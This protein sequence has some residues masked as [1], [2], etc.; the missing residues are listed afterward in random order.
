[1]LK[2]KID[3][4]WEPEDFIEVLTAVESLYYKAVVARPM[5]ALLGAGRASGEFFAS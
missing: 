5:R 2:F 1:M 4:R 3:G